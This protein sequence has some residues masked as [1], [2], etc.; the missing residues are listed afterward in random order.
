MSYQP[1]YQFS[2][3]STFDH[4]SGKPVEI[5]TG[6]YYCRFRER[7]GDPPRAWLDDGERVEVVRYEDGAVFAR[8]LATGEEGYLG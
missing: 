6:L 5:K 8:R 1:G 7:Y 2:V 4:S 3:A